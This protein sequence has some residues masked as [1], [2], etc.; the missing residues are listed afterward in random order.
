MNKTKILKAGITALIMLVAVMQPGMAAS[1][2]VSVTGI[3][4]VQSQDLCAPNLIGIGV[5]TNALN[6]GTL[7]AG[8]NA[9]ENLA[10]TVSTSGYEANC[11]DVVPQTVPVMVA[12][13]DWHGSVEAN[14]M[15][16][17]VTVVSGLPGVMDEY[18]FNPFPIG[19][20]TPT[21]TVN[22][23][24]SAVPDT[25]TQIITITAMY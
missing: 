22:L 3:V 13:Q 2:G 1:N 23:P 9:S 14:T 5:D 21:F 7:I 12:L 18:G 25:Y 15:D 11:G 24:A 6:F 17:D 20:T 19:T 16:K 4:K 8:K 10:V